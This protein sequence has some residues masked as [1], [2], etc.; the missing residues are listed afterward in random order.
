MRLVDLPLFKKIFARQKARHYEYL[1]KKW[2]A[3]HGELRE[4]L[5]SKH[6]DSLKW[7]SEKVSPQ[8][9]AAGSLGG[10]MLLSVPTAS[11]LSAGGLPEPPANIAQRTASKESVLAAELSGK[12][13]P[14]VRPLTAE[15]ERDIV[16]VLTKSFGFKVVPE[17]EGKRLNRS[18]GLIGGEQHL[19][20][21]PGDFLWKHFETEEES[22][23]FGPSGIAPG[24]GA[25]RYFAPSE[26]E[27]TQRDKMRERFYIAVQ[28]FLAPGFS[29]RVREYVDFF[30]FRKMIVVNP[31]T[32]QSVVTVVGDAGPAEWTGKHLGGSPEVMYYLGLDKGPR[33]GPVLF[34]FID[35]PEDKIALGPVSIK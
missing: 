15:E 1:S 28:T 32:G 22:R 8:Q 7:L 16:E 4:R 14:E 27:F 12:L 10:L 19:Y 31:E 29:E 25:W 2:T 11:A 6:G 21:F 30:K 24:L 3:R 20:R 9:L 34:F 13:P 17:M 26:A 23:L 18:F 35:D 5:G 33:K